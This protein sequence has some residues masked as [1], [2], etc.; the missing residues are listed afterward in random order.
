MFG[1]LPSFYSGSH[2][3]GVGCLPASIALIII[4]IVIIGF[5]SFMYWV[6]KQADF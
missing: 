6:Y 5:F 3:K 2:G 1:P 4:F